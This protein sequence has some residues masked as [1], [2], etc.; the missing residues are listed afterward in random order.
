MST[1]QPNAIYVYGGFWRRTVALAVDAVILA[2]LADVLAIPAT[3]SLVDRAGRFMFTMGLAVGHGEGVL[4]WLGYFLIL[5]TWTQATLGKRALGLRVVDADGR[6]PSLVQILLRE[7]VGR[8]LSMLILFIGYLVVTFTDEKRGLHDL[9]GGTWV[10]RSPG[11]SELDAQ[12]RLIERALAAHGEVAPNRLTKV[13]VSGRA[14]LLAEYARWHPEE[15]VV[16]DGTLRLTG[17]VELI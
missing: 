8:P 10:V 3:S 6:P 9:I 15:A 2:L 13:H 17:M 14:P 12:L 5:T 16:S 11:S 1:P 4:L 7:I